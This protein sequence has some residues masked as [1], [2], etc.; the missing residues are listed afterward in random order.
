MK[1]LSAIVL[2]LLLTAVWVSAQDIVAEELLKKLDLT[3]NQIEQVLQIQETYQKQIREAA[4]EMNVYKAE[5]EKLLFK[6]DPDMSKV[7]KLL[8]ESLKWRLQSEMAAITERVET[9]K[10][11]G[12]EKWGQMLRLKK[13]LIE[14]KQMQTQ[15]R[16]NT[17][18]GGKN[19][20][21][22]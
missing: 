11:M 13:R 22:N 20:T 4:L 14:R 21:G 16:S 7:K 5:L 19:G 9:R 1:K 17:L 12:E 8:E 3:Q 6:E 10:I 15:P 18:P 2:I